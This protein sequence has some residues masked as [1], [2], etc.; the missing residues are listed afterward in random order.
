LAAVIGGW[1][2]LVA[3]FAA[4]LVL[5][6]RL[7]NAGRGELAQLLTPESVIF[8]PAILSAAVVGAALILRRPRHPVGWL[9]LAL[10]PAISASGTALGYAA[11]G[12][13]VRP[14]ALPAAEFV[15]VVEDRSF[16][17][18]L[19]LLALILLFTPDGRLNGRIWRFAAWAAIIGG[20][21]GF[22]VGLFRP[23]DGS[24]AALAAIENPLELSALVGPLAVV[25]TTAILVLHAGV[26]AGAASLV[27]R[28]RSARGVAR[29]RLRWL[30]VAA[31]PFP[32]FVVGAYVAATLDNELIL[33]LMG[34]GFVAII[35]VTVALAIEQYHLYDVDRLLSRGLTYSLLTALLVACYTA[36]VVFVG[37][38]LGSLGGD[39]QIPAVVATLAA[40]SVAG[41]A[42]RW[43]QDGLDRRF[44]RRRFEAVASIRRYVREPSPAVTVEQALRAALGDEQLGVA[45]WIDEHERWVSEGGAPAGP[46]PTAVTV[47]RRGAL[48]AAI[49]FDGARVERGTVEVAAAEARAELENAR[50]RAA[51][52]RQLVEVRES[53]A[54][55]VAAQ[56][57]ERRKIERN[58]HDGAQQR[59]LAL[60]F[61]LRAAEVSQSPERARLTIESA[62]EQLQLA[63][64][65]LRDLAN[66][67]HP[68]S[69]SDGG[70]GAALDDLATRTPL[71]IRLD[72][73]EERFAP[74]VEQTAW[75]IVC[76][77]VANA[78][79]HAQSRSVAIS[80]S[81]ED[82]HLRLVVEDDGVGGADPAGQGL[83]GIADRA[84][85]AGGRLAV[86][87]R[88]GGGTI[89]IAEL[90][91]GS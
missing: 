11:Y 51:I 49:T 7:A 44:N 59:L 25:S 19:T 54:R 60:A 24:D 39:S 64:R 72:A 77:A 57:A 65:E 73:T 27:V 15:A 88:P 28:Y 45:Y 66:G 70:L 69:L 63:V 55:I 22:G 47:Q 12:A 14:G 52:A 41:P 56:V 35:P 37:E 13:V 33:I 10:A 68:A 48:I 36:V 80:A 89:V 71:P 50:L 67:L 83:R 1:A 38:S 31:I 75:F 85:A 78:V 43:L 30:A 46:D 79:K 32:V 61:Q 8:V 90:P 3:D 34:G 82:G 23:Y 91:C 58:L 74:E 9:F 86:A 17:I 20:A 4:M 76:E 87:E 53:R 21:V 29:R 2:V 26:L 6:I 16:I 40:V 62:V 18:W 5:D 84:E 81:R 42:R